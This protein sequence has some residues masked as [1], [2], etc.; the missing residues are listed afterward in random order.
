MNDDAFWG[1]VA[2]RRSVRRYRSDP[3]SEAD[4]EAI[5]EA[6][7]WAPSPHNS[8]PWLFAASRDRIDLFADHARSMGTMDPLAREVALSLGC[9]LENLVLAAGAHGLHA[10]YA[11]QLREPGGKVGRKDGGLVPAAGSPAGG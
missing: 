2:G 1:L 3:V 7:R 5:L 6:A 10:G 4:L 11:R 8:Q 9:A